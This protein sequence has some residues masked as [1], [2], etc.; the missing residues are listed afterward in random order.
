MKWSVYDLSWG[1]PLKSI[2][3]LF[4][5][6]VV[7]FNFFHLKSND[8]TYTEDINDDKQKKVNNFKTYLN[9]LKSQNI[10]LDQEKRRTMIVKK[11]STICRKNDR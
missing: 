8:L 4:N 2:V 1:R 3:A 10:V 7:N 9:I 11:F 5:S 6:E